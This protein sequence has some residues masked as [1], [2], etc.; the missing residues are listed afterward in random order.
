MPRYFFDLHDGTVFRDEQ[1]V[2]LPDLAAAREE[3]T[4][5]L[6]DTVQDELPRDGDDRQIK[7]I[8]R[9]EDGGTLMEV[10]V[11]YLVRPPKE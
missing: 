7:V 1:G 5:A 10:S 2:E 6:A 4:R 3:A 11:A 8:V 9:G